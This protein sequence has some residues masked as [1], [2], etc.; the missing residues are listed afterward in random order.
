MKPTSCK[1]VLSII[2]LA[3]NAF[4]IASAA[5]VNSITPCEKKD[6]ELK[7]IDLN[8]KFLKNPIIG[9]DETLICAII[10]KK[11][12]EAASAKQEIKSDEIKSDV[13]GSSPAVTVVSSDKEKSGG[14]TS[15]DGTTLI[16]PKL[17][18]NLTS[19]KSDHITDMPPLVQEPKKTQTVGNDNNANQHSPPNTESNSAQN[20]VVNGGTSSSATG[21]GTNVDKHTDAKVTADLTSTTPVDNQAT[22]D[23]TSTKPVDNQVT[24]DLTSTKPVDNQVTAD[25]TSTKP[26]DNH[27]IDVHSTKPVIDVASTKPVVDVDSANSS[28]SSSGSIVV[29]STAGVRNTQE[30]LVP[31][32]TNQPPVI[33]ATLDHGVSGNTALSTDKDKPVSNTS[34]LQSPAINLNPSLNANG[35]TNAANQSTGNDSQV[36]SQEKIDAAKLASMQ[37]EINAA[38]L[39]NKIKTNETVKKAA[40]IFKSFI[41]TN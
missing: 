37:T 11:D 25:L 1:S 15:G 3:T 13:P 32:S 7:I 36:Q 5:D 34:A 6:P 38:D 23:L 9:A 29:E 10:P 19:S 12:V 40:E 33:N 27:V 22:V 20:V 35:Q 16:D 2:L 17:T 24:A 39:E 14:S 8:G 31:S 21:T 28:N 4:T 18:A 30:N 26:V 41:K